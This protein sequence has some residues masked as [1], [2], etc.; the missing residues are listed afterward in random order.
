MNEWECAPSNYN[1]MVK[2]IICPTDFSDVAVNGIEYAA[3]IAQAFNAELHVLN[4]QSLFPEAVIAGP[5][6]REAV[7]MASDKIKAVCDE[8][9][10]AFRISCSYDVEVTNSSLEKAITKKSGGDT[11][12]VMGTNGIDDIYQYLFGTNTY[13]VVKK[14]KCPVL[15]VPEQISFGT[16]KKIV[17]AWDYTPRNKAA[18]LQVKD[19][20]GVFKPE[21]I[22]LHV[23]RQFTDISGDV[24]R[25]VQEE[26][27]SL[28]AE[29]P[30]VKFEHLYSDELEEGIDHYM[31][32]S[33][34][35]VLAMT[36]HHRNLL[37]RIL[38]PSVT[39]GLSARASYPVL[40]LPA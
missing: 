7:L 29:M 34:A 9:G 4:V 27:T 22:F 8:A 6:I 31:I 23:S 26:F 11:V 1:N 35:D 19:L 10:R 40:M 39:K 33:N 3:K 21:I 12:I 20:M 14:S 15:L 32:S 25:V 30:N 16:I 18:V 37:S 24:F 36:F 28:L 2:K 17:F 5:N 38:Y 13:N